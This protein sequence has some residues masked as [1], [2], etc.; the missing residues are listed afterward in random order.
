M[1]TGNAYL[2]KA[3]LIKLVSPRLENSIIALQTFTK[4][5]SSKAYGCLNTSILPAFPSLNNFRDVSDFR[6]QTL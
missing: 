3:Y 2:I 4:L 5:H 1:Q 6:E